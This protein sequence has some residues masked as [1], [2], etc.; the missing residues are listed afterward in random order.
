MIKE[1]VKDA[2]DKLKLE[3]A[4]AGASS[5]VIRSSGSWTSGLQRSIGACKV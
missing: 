3:C 2:K 4:L 5:A 1:A